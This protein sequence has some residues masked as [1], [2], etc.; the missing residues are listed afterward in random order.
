MLRIRKFPRILVS[1]FTVGYIF[2]FFSLFDASKRIFG[3]IVFTV[4][5]VMNILYFMSDEFRSASKLYTARKLVE[6]GEFERAAKLIVD[7]CQIMSNEEALTHINA[8]K[9]DNLD[10]YGKTAEILLRSIK[11]D[12]PVF[13]RFV[14]G[15]FFYVSRNLAK[16]RDVMLE[17]PEEKLTIKMARLLG[18]ILYE[19]RK[20][21]EAIKVFSVYDPPYIPMSQDELA[22]VY[23]IGICYMAKGEN[24]KAVEALGRVEAKSPSYGNVSRLIHELTSEKSSSNDS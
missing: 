16:A 15:S 23:G 10:N 1:L 6:K 24:Q 20:Y 18:S 19:L 8:S 2:S 12:S 14:T 9:K 5:M 22:I 3:A 21:D 7:S 4:S 13:L 17:I 11:S